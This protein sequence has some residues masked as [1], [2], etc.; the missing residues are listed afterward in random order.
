ME[1]VSWLDKNHT[2]VFIVSSNVWE[3]LISVVAVGEKGRWGR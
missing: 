2:E 3:S 1:V